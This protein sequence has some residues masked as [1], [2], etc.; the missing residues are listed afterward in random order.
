MAKKE[1][2]F[3]LGGMFKSGMFSGIISYIMDLPGKVQDF[4]INTEE[5]VIQMF[6]SAA[7]L[8]TGL[9]FLSISFVFLM[10]EYFALSK[11]WSL[12][13]IGLILIIAAMLMRNRTLD[14]ITKRR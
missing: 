8:V 7:L 13:I 2:G 14:N 9:I 4:I 3:D 1:G 5:K 10:N 12:L 11:G 6:Y